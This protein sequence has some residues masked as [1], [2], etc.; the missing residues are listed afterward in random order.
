MFY[1][2]FVEFIQAT[3]PSIELS[4]RHSSLFRILT[5]NDSVRIDRFELLFMLFFFCSDE[6]APSNTETL[7]NLFSY[8]SN[9]FS[10]GISSFDP[11][12]R[13]VL[14][15]IHMMMPQLLLYLR[16]DDSK[17]IDSINSQLFAGCSGGKQVSTISKELFME[18]AAKSFRIDELIRYGRALLNQ[19][20][21]TLQMTLGMSSI[22]LESLNSVL[23]CVRQ[24][25]SL[26]QKEF[27][28]V[29]EIV[30]FES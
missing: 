19:R 22:N 16:Q 18:N 9:S 8:T 1:S 17:L 26:S 2:E 23:N 6:N 25:D 30:L 13:S 14:T 27:I 20:V 5:H 3:F 10:E 7:Y 11:F 21:E 4:R 24:N 28:D 12:T 15:L 29:C